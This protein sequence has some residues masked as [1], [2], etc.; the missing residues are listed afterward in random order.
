M[1]LTHY[2]AIAVAAVLLT[3]A[4]LFRP[5]ARTAIT[6]LGAFLAWGLVA[7]LGG[8]TETHAD[9]GA[10]LVNHTNGTTAVATGDQL[11]AAPVPDEIRLFA[12]LWALLSG[13]ALILYVWG[14]YPPESE[15][16]VDKSKSP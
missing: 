2:Y 6:T 16:P 7:L 12:A 8:A 5:E 1:L 14:V 3:G 15:Q 4:W 11:V 9:S 10:E 13:L